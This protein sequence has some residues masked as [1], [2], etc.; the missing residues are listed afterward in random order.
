VDGRKL[1]NILITKEMRKQIKFAMK[2][3][4][5]IE[6]IKKKIFLVSSTVKSGHKTMYKV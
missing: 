6:D 5:K 1:P 3:G 2:R 4:D